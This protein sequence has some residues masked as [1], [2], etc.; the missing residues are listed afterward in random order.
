ML[1][2]NKKYMYIGLIAAIAL[3]VAGG[4]YLMF[5]YS[6][7]CMNYECWQKYMTACSKATFINE[8]PEASWE[9]NIKGVQNGQCV[10]TVKLLQAKK[11]ELGIDKIVG[12]EMTCYYK[13]GTSAYVEKDISKCHGILKEDLQQII[14]NKLHAYLLENLDKLNASMSQI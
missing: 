14:V 2:E 8:E 3:C 10:I 6:P 11:G 13:V 5:F 12:E 1:I 4:V 9:Y 7:E